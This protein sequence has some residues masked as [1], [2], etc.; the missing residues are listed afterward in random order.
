MTRACSGGQILRNLAH[1][2]KR[3]VAMRQM[4]LVPASEAHLLVLQDKAPLAVVANSSAFFTGLC[5]KESD[6]RGSLALST[7]GH[8]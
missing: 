2:S 8:K 6:R 3:I 5:E 1:G 7:V 4:S